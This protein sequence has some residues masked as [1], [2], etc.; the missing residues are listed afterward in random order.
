MNF[1]ER[2]KDRDYLGRAQE[3]VLLDANHEKRRGEWHGLYLCTC[4]NIAIKRNADVKAGHTKSCGCLKKRKS[5]PHAEHPLYSVRWDMVQRCYNPNNYQ[6]H[7]YGGRGIEISKEWLDTPA[8]F[9]VWGIMNGWKKG[10]QI[11][12]TDNN[13]NYEPSN[14]RFVTNKV[15]SRNSRR[16]RLT[17]DYVKDIKRRLLQGEKQA[18]IARAYN[19]S[20][21]AIHHIRKGR[22]WED[23]N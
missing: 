18:D 2:C 12:R 8:S 1:T 5:N 3:L 19:V 7:R 17:V 14:C 4:G 23:V 13:G 6:Y 16:T 15:N 21:S 10:L 9:V 20:P 22:R 11:D